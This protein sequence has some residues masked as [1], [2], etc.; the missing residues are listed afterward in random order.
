MPQ[1]PVMQQ[2]MIAVFVAIFIAL[3]LVSRRAKGAPAKTAAYNARTGLIFSAILVVWGGA[4]W[5]AILMSQRY[6]NLLAIVAASSLLCIGLYYL[7]K[8][9]RRSGNNGAGDD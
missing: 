9:L 4:I 2:V 3:V 5:F 8:G 7:F 1:S 6:D